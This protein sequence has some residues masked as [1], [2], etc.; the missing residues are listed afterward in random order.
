MGNACGAT[1]AKPKASPLIKEPIKPQSESAPTKSESST[2]QK[3]KSKSLQP[4][5][6]VIVI[7]ILNFIH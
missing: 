7:G 2:V 4:D 5:Y 1:N 3:T 6:E